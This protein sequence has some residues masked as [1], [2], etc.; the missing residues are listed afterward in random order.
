MSF[1]AARLFLVPGFS[2]SFSL[3]FAEAVISLIVHLLLQSLALRRHFARIVNQ[4]DNRHL[5]II[6]RASAKFDYPGVTPVPILV[7]RAE[8]IEQTFHCGDSGRS[9]DR[10]FRFTFLTAKTARSDLESAVSRVEISGGLTSEMNFSS[11]TGASG[12]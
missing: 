4:F 2:N 9:L 10:V 1:F 3:A 5:G 12:T 6:A 8:L 11:L 7:T